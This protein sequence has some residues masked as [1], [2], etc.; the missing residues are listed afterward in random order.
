MQRRCSVEQAVSASSDADLTAEKTEFLTFEVT[1]EAVGLGRF[2]VFVARSYLKK[3]KKK[4][5]QEVGKRQESVGHF[6]LES[7][8]R[9]RQEG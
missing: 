9:F 6:T 2:V 8:T 4:N 7:K 1:T 3:K 5:L